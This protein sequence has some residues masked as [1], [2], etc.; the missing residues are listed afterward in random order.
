M[1]TPL[2]SSLKITQPEPVALFVSD[3]HLSPTL[4]LTTAAFLD[5]LHQH[6]PKTPMLFILGDLF[7]YWIGDDDIGDPYHRHIVEA[8][9]ELKNSGTNI[10]F[11]AGN[12]DF[13]ISDE[14]ARVTGA[15][16]LQEPYLLQTAGHKI[17]LC[18]GD[19]E[20]TD[21]TDY[22]A[23]RQQVRHAQW[24]RNFLALP[25]EQRKSMVQGMRA[26]SQAE[27]QKKS[28]QIMDVNQ[29]AIARLVQ[30]AGADLMIHGH[31][32]R[33]AEHAGDSYRRLV[34]PD[35][36]YDSANPRG[37]WLELYDDGKLISC[38]LDQAY[39]PA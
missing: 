38:T 10:Y 15:E 7:E 36:D 13:L 12:R 25:L 9:Q 14:F 26:S 6:A 18:H 19:A 27:Q 1:A 20:C 29:D 33:P 16:I 4:P 30:S 2:H 22:M 3:I 35:W 17:V 8:L 31:T 24:Q 32:H 21:D 11:M 5:F 28:M 39:N 34:L 23:F 37:G